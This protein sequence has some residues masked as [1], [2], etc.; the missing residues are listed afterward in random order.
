MLE[1]RDFYHLPQLEPLVEQLVGGGPGLVVVAG[2]DPG[3]LAYASTPGGFLP[4]G[5]GAFLRLLMRKMLAAR[6]GSRAIVVAEP[7]DPLR[8]ARGARGQIRL[9]EVEPSGSYSATIQAASES[10]PDLLVIGRL[11][12]GNAPAAL[13][14]ARKGLRV[15]S[16]FNTIH[17]G[18]GV[19]RQLLTSQDRTGTGQRASGSDDRL[20][21][22]AWVVAMQ[23]LATLCP[24]CRE[25]TSPGPH[26]A[27]EVQFR[28]PDHTEL[29]R[30]GTFFRAVGCSRCH[31]TGHAG[32]VSAFD[33]YRVGDEAAGV[34]QSASLLAMEVYLLGLA[35]AG[36]LTL[37]DVLRFE[38]EQLRRTYDLLAAGEPALAGARV[39]LQRKLAELEAANQVLEQR[40]A[41]LI[42]LEGIG[43]ALSDATTLS[44]LAGQLCRG[45]RDLCGADRSILYYRHPEEAKAEVLAEHGWDPSLVGQPLDAALVFGGVAA[46]QPLPFN[47]RPPGVPRRPTDVTAAALRAGL[48]VP[49]VAQEDLVGL[50]IVHTSQKPR[51]APGDVALLQTFANQAAVA[52][53]RA[54]LIEELQDKI[55]QLEAAQVE[56]VQK[57][58]LEREMELARQVQQSVLPRVFPHSPGYAFGARNEPARHVGGDFYDVIPLDSERFAIA[59]GDVSDKGMAAA[60]YMAQTH[61]LLLAEARRETVPGAVLGNVHRLLQDLGRSGMYVT[62]FLGIVDGPARRLTYARA[63]HDR[64]LLLRDGEVLA[65]PGDG[66]VLGFPGMDDLYLSEEEMDLAPG[67]RLVLYTDGLI[68]IQA[69]DG[70]S[71]GVERIWDL[72]RSNAHLPAGELCAAVFGELAAFQDVAEQY[73][74]MTMLVVEVQ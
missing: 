46:R 64:P 42:S 62:V 20:E 61:S 17:R 50:M 3:D 53:Q 8:V 9:M 11:T 40:T 18:A 37:D 65:L 67:D 73:D 16:Q 51:F 19:E 58:R 23:R 2:L 54:G 34:S 45:A 22:L 39:E 6:P 56:L 49:L 31:G 43:Q 69:P 48:C 28:Y 57:E 33:I 10:R 1:L 27:A 25:P 52:I 35:A 41:A 70:R 68:D 4:S 13:A 60:L 12:V 32:E 44:D 55:Q 36:Q 7:D 15:L 21:G 26:Q 38:A 71:F 59:I 14:A 24:A 47:R 66:T 74:D 5:K 29:L 30:Q 63:G 72:L